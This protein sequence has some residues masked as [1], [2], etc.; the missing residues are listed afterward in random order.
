VTLARTVLRE[1]VKEL[2]IQRILDGT[3]PPGSRVVESQ[4]AGEFGVSQAPVREALRDLEALRFIETAPYKGARVR[5]VSAEELG[6]IYPVRAVLEEL[7]GRAAA[8]RVTDQTLAQ[9]EEEL[10]GMRA[11]ADAGDVHAQLMHDARFHELIIEAAGNQVLLE[12]WGSLR[13]EAMTLVSVI[14]AD[15]DLHAIAARHVPLLEALRLRD[16]ELAG[17]E[18]RDHIEFFGSQVKGMQA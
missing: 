13:I 16:P 1:Q 17:K 9:L 15:S 2:I 5:D 10:A 12:V 4:L 18:L 14:K 11:A 6:E 3:Y 7:A 8:P